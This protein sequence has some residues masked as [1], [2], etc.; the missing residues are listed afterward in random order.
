MCPRFSFLLSDGYILHI[1]YIKSVALVSCSLD[2]Y[3]KSFY[4]MSENTLGKLTLPIKYL[5]SVKR[6][7]PSV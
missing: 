1:F 3:I 2:I 7:L 4:R 6:F 5:S